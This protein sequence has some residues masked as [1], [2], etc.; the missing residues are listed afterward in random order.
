MS[1]SYLPRS[2][3]RAPTPSDVGEGSYRPAANDPLDI[4]L[5]R[6]VNSLPVLLRVERLDA[7]LERRAEVQGVGQTAKYAI[8]LSERPRRTGEGAVLC[9]L[10][11]R[12]GRG[13]QR[14]ETKVVVQVGG[15][16]MELEMWALDVLAGSV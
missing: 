7:P 12:L 6:V 1:S 9:K 3:A 13:V 11:E 4:A 5:S 10:V 16:W 8:S 2:S 15:G 14:G